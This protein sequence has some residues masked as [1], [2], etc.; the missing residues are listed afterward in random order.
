MSERAYVSVTSAIGA[1]ASGGSIRTLPMWKG[2]FIARS[3][4]R[5]APRMFRD[6]TREE[7]LERL[8]LPRVALLVGIEVHHL[9]DL[10][11]PLAQR[12]AEVAL[13]PGALLVLLADL[14]APPAHVRPAAD[15]RVRQALA[16]AV[17]GVDLQPV[18]GAAGDE[19]LLRAPHLGIDVRMVDIEE[20]QRLGR[21]ARAHG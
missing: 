8:R 12:R 13:R 9:Y 1:S 20:K 10:Q 15:E 21:P 19:R 17:Q 14:H 2:A 16:F 18:I 6:P 7:Q 4:T 11:P 5:P 3:S